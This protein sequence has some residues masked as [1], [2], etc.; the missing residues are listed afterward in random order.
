MVQVMLVRDGLCERHDDSL[1]CGYIHLPHL[2]TMFVDNSHA[3]EGVHDPVLSYRFLHCI[4]SRG[5]R[6]GKLINLVSVITLV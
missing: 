5:E 4:S 2:S 3:M 6:D 1:T